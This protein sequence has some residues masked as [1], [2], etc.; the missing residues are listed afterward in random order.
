MI[1][2]QKVLNS[3]KN[4]EGPTDALIKQYRAV[5][6]DFDNFQKVPYPRANEQTCL[7]LIKNIIDLF[8][9]EPDIRLRVNLL[10]LNKGFSID[11]AIEDDLILR[12]DNI[13]CKEN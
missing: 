8:P 9:D 5:Y 6:P 2:V 3:T 1:S 13:E 12:G 4:A 7:K 11:N 10:W